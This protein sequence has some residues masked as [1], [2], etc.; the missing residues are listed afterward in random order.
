MVTARRTKGWTI[1]Q[2]A[3]KLGVDPTTW[4]DWERMGRVPWKGYQVRLEA[5][6]NELANPELGDLDRQVL[7]A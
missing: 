2:A 4:G 7:P 6:L 3:K 1:V 5:F